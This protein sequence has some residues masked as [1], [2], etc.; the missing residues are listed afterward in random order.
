MKE[1]N[2]KLW[3]EFRTNRGNYDLRNRL[4]EHYAPLVPPRADRFY[5]EL[6]DDKIN[7]DDLVSLG[8]F[9][10]IDAINNYNPD[11]GTS[12]EE[13]SQTRID[14]AMVELRVLD[15]L[16][17]HILEKNGWINDEENPDS[18]ENRPEDREG[19]DGAEG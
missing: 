13:Y 1:P 18:P 15:G 8:Y 4:I 7:R 14:G 9:G 19:W 3:E 6:N 11:S 12:F 2:K 17:R 10:L 5:A 16:P